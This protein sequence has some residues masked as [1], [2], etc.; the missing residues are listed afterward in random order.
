MN[1]KRRPI[2]HRKKQKI[3]ERDNFTCQKCG[4]TKNLAFLEVD[5][6]IPVCY[7]GTNEVNNLQTL[8]YRCNMNKRWNTDTKK[9]RIIEN[10]SPRE[11]LEMINH[12]LKR[13]ADLTWGEFKVLFTQD[14]FFKRF[15]LNLGD[16]YDL[17]VELSGNNRNKDKLNTQRDALICIIRKN[18]KLSYR[19]IEKMLK[20]YNIDISYVQIRNICAKFDDTDKKIGQ[21]GLKDVESVEND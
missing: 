14:N 19:T 13:Y 20:E 9:R 5:H 18:Y 2:N 21:I 8:C 1:R 12:R 4:I 3:L 15:T 7:G 17:F 11:R 16:V 10:S 6:I